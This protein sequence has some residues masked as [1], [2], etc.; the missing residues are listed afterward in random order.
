[1]MRWLKRL[2]TEL[3]AGAALGFVVWCFAGKAITSFRFGSLG[4]SFSCKGDV[5]VALDQFVAMQLYSAIGGGVVLTIATELVRRAWSKRSAKA[6][7]PSPAPATLPGS[8]DPVR[9]DL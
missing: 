4:G 3:V 1:M 8:A 7:A 9:R 5:S 6:L 2:L